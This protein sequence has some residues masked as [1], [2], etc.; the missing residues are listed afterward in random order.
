MPLGFSEGTSWWMGGWGAGNGRAANRFFRVNVSLREALSL[1]VDLCINLW[2][3]F[4]K[5]TSPF[6]YFLCFPAVWCVFCVH[7]QATLDDI[8]C[9]YHVFLKRKN[10]GPHEAMEVR[11]PGGCLGIQIVTHSQMTALVSHKDPSFHGW[12]N[13]GLQR[14]NGL[15]EAGKWMSG[16]ERRFFNTLKIHR[17]LKLKGTLRISYPTSSTFIN[18]GASVLVNWPC[19][20]CWLHWVMGW[21]LLSKKVGLLSMI[22]L[23]VG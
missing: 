23:D 19:G 20:H 12:W 3:P 10:R 17:V 1:P 22:S 9:L 18:S 4:S 15:L 11:R 2:H 21:S 16:Y 5:T 7:M 6:T 8:I 13:L 14:K